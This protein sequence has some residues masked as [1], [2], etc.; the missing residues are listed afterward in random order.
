MEKLIKDIKKRSPEYGAIP[1][2]SW[3][4]KL[5]ENELRSQIRTMKE[6]GMG[7]FF[8][9]ARGGLE[10]EYLSDDWFN[11][12]NVCIDEAKKLGM[13]AWSYD[14]NGWPS[15][16]AGGKLLEDK[17]NFAVCIRHETTEKFP[18]PDPDTIAVYTRNEDGTFNIVDKDC[19]AKE[20]LR[21]YKG[22]DSSYVDTLDGSITEKFIKETHEVYLKRIPKEDAGTVMPGFFTDEPQYYRWDNPYS[23]TLPAEFKKAYGYEIYPLLPAVFYDFEGAEK[24]RYDYYKLMHELFINNF[25]KKIYDWCSA[26]G[27]QL[28]GHAIEESSLEGQMMCCGGIMPFYEYEHIPGIDYLGRGI[29]DDI[30]PKQ[31]GSVCEQLGKKKAISEMFGCCG[32]DVTPTE[33][34]RIADVQ[35]ANGVNLMCA[36][37]APYSERGQRKRDYPNHYSFHNPWQSH[38][39]QFDE[40]FN[41]LGSALTEGKEYAPVLVIHPIHGAYMK[42]KK[43]QGTL[44][45]IEGK[46]FELSRLLGYNQ[47]PYHYG[48]ENM[49]KSHASVENGKIKVGNCTYDAVIVPFTYTLDKSTAELIKKLIADGGKVW[50]FGHPDCID[51]EK[52]DM[53][54]LRDTCTKEDIF[55]LRD[56]VITLENGQNA[57]QIRKM[58]R[59]TD[60]GK[61]IY[62]T[63]VTG[64]TLDSVHVKLDKS[65]LMHGGIAEL[66]PETLELSPVCGKTTEDGAELILNFEEG[67][68]YLLV[69]ADL[70]FTTE[71][72]IPDTIPTIELP[73]VM[74]IAE[75]PVNMINLDTAEL[76]TDGV[77]FDE[78]LSVMGIKDNLLRERYDGDLW[79]RFTF[80]ASAEY[81]KSAENLRISVEPMNVKE[82]RI[83]GSEV[84]EIPGAWWFDK[85]FT[86]YDI[87]PYTKE[88]RNE[89][90]IKLHHWQRDYVYYVLYGG[91]SESLRNCLVFDCEVEDIYLL[92]DF[93]V[94]CDGKFTDGERRSVLFDGK[95]S[96]EPQRDEIHI[97][98]IVTD[99]YPFYAGHFKSSFVYNYS[100]GMP[101]VLKLTGRYAVCDVTVNGSEAGTLMFSNYLDLSDHLREGKNEIILNMCNS[102]RN[103]M[104]PHH[105]HD[106]EPYALGPNTFSYEKEWNGRECD[107]YVE[108]YA[109]VRYGFDVK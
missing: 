47:V 10:T 50:C 42:Y 56:A 39:A 89:I 5:E 55:A 37:L 98:D 4:D 20:Y 96:L 102:N 79:L 73:S 77:N 35:Y 67:Q 45:E 27:M 32:W 86:V 29:A 38:L 106:P 12:I 62:I 18:E 87:L 90:T 82:V 40:Y 3:N 91:V 15:G 57:P 109:F 54:W 33:L 81:I 60:E 76:S 2:W 63:N 28:T 93:C 49:M 75:K 107:G 41:N 16:F 97:S 26:H 53:T 61:L 21:L 71:N 1:F 65:Y 6:L 85:K 19:G 83:N 100:E 13:E 22:Y 23:N 14:E 34:K 51:G 64:E 48:D 92:G 74:K 84:Y 104:G 66:D 108:R 78:P 58:T 31:L 36:H 99:G 70:P 69:P 9:H 30:A 88:G 43:N 17:A 44:G 68:S 101:T 103:L 95:F 80:D 11:C 52:A 46:F 72:V 105:R 24:F 7:G 8:M 25:V 59:V 94:K